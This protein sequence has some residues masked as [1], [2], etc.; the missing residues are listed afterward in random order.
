[1][2][3]ILE[4][5]KELLTAW[6]E[7]SKK[8]RIVIVTSGGLVA[9]GALIAF[10]SNVLL[11]Y[12]QISKVGENIGIAIATSG[13]VMAFLIVVAQKSKDEVRR[14]EK[15]EEVERRVL[16]NP[17]E[18]QAAWEL[19][20]VKLEDYLN[21]NLT[22][23]NSIFWLT[24]FIMMGGFA[25]I[26]VGVYKAF[27]D[28]TH[29][30]ASIL[31]TASGVL[32]SFIGGTF[33]VIYKATMAQAK[34]Y[35]AILER[36]NAVGMSVQILENIDDNEGKLKNETTAEVAKQLLSMY[37][38]ELSHNKNIQRTQKRRDS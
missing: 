20:R 34:D 28:S 17:K 31:T 19:A 24:L 30:N 32:V 27:Q 13:L 2:T 33:L 36:I 10:L 25:L 3:V 26:S 9:I 4:T 35:V 12:S 5:M 38:D 11:Y 22:Q 14:E 29:F 16:G 18:T 23:V 7:G 8:V 6:R 1:M 21:R 37:S 15:I